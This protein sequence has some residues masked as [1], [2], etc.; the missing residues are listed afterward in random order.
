MILLIS[1]KEVCFKMKIYSI[2]GDLL[3]VLQSE[4]KT[5]SPIHTDELFPGLY[6]KPPL[7]VFGLFCRRPLPSYIVWNFIVK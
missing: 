7:S 6:P 2:V 3:N 5:D 1:M 4:S